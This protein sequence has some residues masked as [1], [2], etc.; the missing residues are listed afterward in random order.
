MTNNLSPEKVA[1]ADSRLKEYGIV[2]LTKVWFQYSRKYN[3]VLKRGKIFNEGEYY[4]IKGIVDD[5]SI[6]LDTFEREKTQ[7]MLDE[8]E[9]K[10]QLMAQ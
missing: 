4:L 3:R 1:A 10:I 2:T 8:Y 9:A 6:E 5:G 7:A